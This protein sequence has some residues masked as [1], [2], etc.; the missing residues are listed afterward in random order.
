MPAPPAS[1]FGIVDAEQSAWVEARLTPHPVKT[2]LAP[3][4]LRGSGGSNL[5]TS[6]V[7]CTNPAYPALRS[8]RERAGQWG[9]PIHELAAGHD[10]MLIAPA[11]TAELVERIA[12][13]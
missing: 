3:L 4:H 8:A 1:A 10:A 2:Y 13:G 9:W 11:A 5:P 12:A 7:V 6:Y